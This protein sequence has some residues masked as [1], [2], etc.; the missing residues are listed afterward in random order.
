MRSGHCLK[1][2]SKTQAIVAKSSGD[3]EL[4]AVVRGA[5]EALGMAILVKDLGR[6]VE[7]QLHIGALAANG[8]ME[9][10]GLWKV[11]HLDVNILWLQEQCARTILPVTKVFGEENPA[12][13]TTKHLVSPKVLKSVGALHMRYLDARAGKAAQLHRLGLPTPPQQAAAGG[14]GHQIWDAMSDRFADSKG[15]D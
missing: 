2:W 3:S 1:T 13:L 8:L 6:K 15:G 10:K 4:Y 5:T 14:V 11:R 7:I 12:D 9:R